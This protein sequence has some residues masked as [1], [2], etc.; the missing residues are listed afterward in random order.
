MARVF[1][2]ISTFRNETN[3]QALRA[4]GG[5]RR[6]CPETF[7]NIIMLSDAVYLIPSQTQYEKTEHSA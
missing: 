6:R 4:C 7:L 2:A 1:Q 3:A 5:P